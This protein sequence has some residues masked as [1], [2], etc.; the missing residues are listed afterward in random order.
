MLV[1]NQEDFLYASLAKFPDWL[2]A[3][4]SRQ[5]KAAKRS[6]S[7]SSECQMVPSLLQLVRRGCGH[8]DAVSRSCEILQS[9]PCEDSTYYATEKSICSGRHLPKSPPPPRHHRY[10]DH[11]TPLALL[12]PASHCAS[13]LNEQRVKWKEDLPFL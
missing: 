2:W 3:F 8:L 12:P 5:N 13:Q 6:V 10:H 7:F 4:V 11:S 1:C 9:L